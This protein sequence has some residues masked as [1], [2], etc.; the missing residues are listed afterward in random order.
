MTTTNKND[1][2]CSHNI[3]TPTSTFFSIGRWPLKSQVAYKMSI[4]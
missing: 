1:V 3:F 2:V 4:P